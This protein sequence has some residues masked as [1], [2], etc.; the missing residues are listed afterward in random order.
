MRLLI[1]IP[2]Y[3]KPDPGGTSLYASRLADPV[4][5]IAGLNATLVGLHRYFGPNHCGLDGRRLDGDKPVPRLDVV[6]LTVKGANVLE[7]IGV[8]PRHYEVAYFDGD[9]MMLGFEVHRVMR[10]RIGGY[11]YYGYAEDDLIID[12]P[13]FFEKLSWFQERFGPRAL[14]Q[15][16]RYELSASG[17]LARIAIDR[18][19]SADQLSPFRRPDQ[20]LVLSAQNGGGVQ[21]FRIASNP[22]SGC[23]FVSEQ[24][25]RLWVDQPCFYDRDVSWRGPIES[26]NTLAAGK[27]FD[28]YKAG[29]PNPWFL[30][31]QHSG[32]RF[33]SLGAPSE[34]YGESPILKYAQDG[35]ASA[36]RIAHD[37]SDSTGAF[38]SLGTLTSEL[39]SLRLQFD[40][41]RS[42][43]RELAR[44]LLW[45]LLRRQP[46][47]IRGGAIPG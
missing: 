16:V 36:G 13:A 18:D 25:L 21:E 11:D 31:I 1:V 9:P 28:L 30:A 41:L 35:F 5:R 17:T 10:E 27:V 42:S 46:P 20:R 47:P 24:Q 6:I 40:L 2:H 23:H 22:H 7:S 26:S 33:A 12:D 39:R 8:S 4:S 43:R 44:H 19:I 37:H 38:K 3:F 14:L 34:D 32:V 29:A 15:P 45:A